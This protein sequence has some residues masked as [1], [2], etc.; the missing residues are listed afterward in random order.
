MKANKYNDNAFV[1]SKLKSLWPAHKL[2]YTDK[3]RNGNKHGVLDNPAWY[4]YCMTILNL[5]LVIINAYAKF[6]KNLNTES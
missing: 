3:T 5:D 1:N 4:C 2:N 6:D